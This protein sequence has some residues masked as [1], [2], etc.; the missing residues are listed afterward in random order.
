MRGSPV[1][2]RFILRTLK[3]SVAYLYSQFYILIDSKIRS[4]SLYTEEEERT[5]L[6]LLPEFNT[7]AS[8]C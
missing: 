1:A 3:T 4:F 5:S 7:K 6:S 2:L 8:S